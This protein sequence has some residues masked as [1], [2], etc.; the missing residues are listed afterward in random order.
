M[1]ILGWNK[2]L[3]FF[4]VATNLNFQI[5][6][7]P[8]FL[9]NS[10]NENAKSIWKLVYGRNVDFKCNMKDHVTYRET[11]CSLFYSSE[12]F[13]CRLRPFENK[14][15]DLQNT[16][17]HYLIVPYKEKYFFFRKSLA[18]YTKLIWPTQSLTKHTHLHGMH[19]R[20]HNQLKYKSCVG[21]PN[22]CKLIKAAKYSSPYTA[23]I[24]LTNYNKIV[25]KRSFFWL[26]YFLAIFYF[27]VWATVAYTQPSAA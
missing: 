19:H 8:H 4:C 24:L 11:I 25:R 2:Y 21:A 20:N 15:I 13:S 26:I 6:R 5:N 7:A 10:K 12:H 9:L 16:N 23:P 17:L 1:V 18:L 27:L 14:R 3:W 22:Q